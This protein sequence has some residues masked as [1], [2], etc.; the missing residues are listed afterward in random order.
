MKEKPM[1]RGMWSL[2]ISNKI[3]FTFFLA[4]ITVAI[5]VG[6][7][8]AYDKTGFSPA[9]T[10]RYYCGDEGEEFDPNQSQEEYMESLKE[11]IYFPKSYRE[12]LGVTHAH[13]F[14][15]PIV[16]FILSRMLA[17]TQLRDWLKIVVYSGSLAGIIMNLCAPWLI[18]YT[19]HHFVI[20]LTISNILFILT[21]GAYIF[22]PLYD[23][24][25]YRGQIK[26]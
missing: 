16:V 2:P 23:M 21:F 25:F 19:S 1:S 9:K 22:F 20:L 12:L 24:W 18:R 17:M 7:W 15:I 10:V 5:G 13:I 3:F 14:S 4:I 11:G 26:K 6:F 8:V